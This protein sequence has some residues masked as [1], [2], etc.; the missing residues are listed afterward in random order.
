MAD[1]LFIPCII[2][3]LLH[4]NAPLKNVFLCFSNFRKNNVI[5]KRRCR[6]STKDFKK[7]K[8]SLNNLRSF[9]VENSRDKYL[10]IKGETGGLGTTVISEKYV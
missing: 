10:N 7:C 2:S 8:G 5:G 9:S 6:V 1:Y 4:Y 3:P